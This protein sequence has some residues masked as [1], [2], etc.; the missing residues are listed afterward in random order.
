MNEQRLQNPRRLGNARRWAWK[1]SEVLKN[2]PILPEDERA[3]ALEDMVR[4]IALMESDPRDWEG[5]EDY[6]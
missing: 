5:S 2:R 6:F 3:D 4:D 1:I